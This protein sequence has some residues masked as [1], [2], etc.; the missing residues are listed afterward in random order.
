MK[1]V[2]AKEIRLDS[3]GKPDIDYYEAEAHH[4]R[5]AMI[6]WMVDWALA[7]IRELLEKSHLLPP[8]APLHG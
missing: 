4:M 5:S 1:H 3:N 7:K 8:R 6:A 2:Y